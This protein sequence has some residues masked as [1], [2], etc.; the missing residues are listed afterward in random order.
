[1]GF[2]LSFLFIINPPSSRR[3]FSRS[4]HLILTCF[5]GTAHN[6]ETDKLMN[7][8][9]HTR[10]LNKWEKGVYFSVSNTMHKGGVY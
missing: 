9:S 3:V 10:T 2:S 8:H 6:M 4:S 5:G 1:M 7:G